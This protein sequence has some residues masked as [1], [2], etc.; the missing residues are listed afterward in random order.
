MSGHLERRLRAIL[1]LYPPAW[2]ARHGEDLIGTLL[3]LAR[4]GQRFPS[5]RETGGLMVG[6]CRE[7][8][9][10]RGLSTPSAVLR[11]GLHLGATLIVGANACIAVFAATGSEDRVAGVPSEWGRGE[12]LWV[13][14]FAALVHGGRLLGPAIVTLVSGLCL[15]AVVAEM[16][17]VPFP[18]ADGWSAVLAAGAVARLIMPA[19][20]L[21]WLASRGTHP[22][23]SPLW[24]LPLAPAA[25]ALTGA[26]DAPLSMGL[27]V[28]FLSAPL[29][30][31]AL[32][33]AP[34]DPRPAIGATL[35]LFAFWLPLATIVAVD[36]PFA[37]SATPAVA[38]E[39]AVLLAILAFSARAAAV[40]VFRT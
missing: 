31:G 16:S 12:L 35:L 28:V 24:L 26:S 29:L 34:L 10:G 2:R 27:S 30:L 37:Y 32:L 9:R 21:I 20:V 17:H 5:L 25:A 6:A 8:M 39:A 18:P 13:V 14:A 23:R 4:P 38:L 11:D 33:L 15:V 1:V 19:A 3:D 36:E 7:R 40:R 22:D